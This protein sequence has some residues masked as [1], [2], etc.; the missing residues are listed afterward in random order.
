MTIKILSPLW[1]HEHLEYKLFLDKMREAGYDGFDTWVPENSNE[2][3]LLFD[4]LQKH[5]MYIVTH[6]HQAAG[7][8][9]EAFKSSF[10]KNLKICAE[11][12]PILINSHT[13]RDYFSLEQNL[14]LIDIAQEFSEKTGITVVHETHRGRVGYSPQM[15]NEIFQAR[16]EFLLTADFSHW[17]CVTESMLENFSEILDEAINRSR[18]I[19]TRVGFEEGPQVSDPRAE[20][21]AYAVEKFFGWWD[22]IV[23][24][25]EKAGVEIM[26]VTTE[27]G[28]KPY[29]PSIPFTNAPVADQFEIN[30]YMKDLLHTRYKQYR[31]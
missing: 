9:F 10:A 13:G 19:H 29:M 15:T 7:D 23:A 31:N 5:E 2:K 28:P 3:K 24:V 18:H 26:P 16:K 11:P 6:Q 27:F 17:V 8:T 22:R 12:K 1:G 14:E 4:Y 21:W 25:N 20:E 30:C